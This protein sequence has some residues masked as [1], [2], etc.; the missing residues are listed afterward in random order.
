MHAREEEVLCG[1]RRAFVQILLAGSSVTCS[2][3][4]ILL[5]VVV[6]IFLTV[7]V[8][9]LLTGVLL[10]A[11]VQIRPKLLVYATLSY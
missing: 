7:L 11:L 5:T 10:T 3:V 9:I 2:L 4:Q 6:H 8:Q 1:L